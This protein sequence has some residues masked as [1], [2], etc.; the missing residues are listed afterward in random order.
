MNVFFNLDIDYCR[1]IHLSENKIVYDEDFLI[2]TDKTIAQYFMSVLENTCNACSKYNAQ[3]S[4]F[5]TLI[6][7]CRVCKHCLL[8]KLKTATNEKIYLN[9]YEK[10]I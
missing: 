2:L 8:R 1:A 9:P 6:C 5:V 7:E 10:S 4:S 3:N